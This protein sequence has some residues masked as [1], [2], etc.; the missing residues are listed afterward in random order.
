[1]HVLFSKIVKHKQWLVNT[2]SEKNICK[3]TCLKETACWSNIKI[4]AHACLLDLFSFKLYIYT[5]KQPSEF[6]RVIAI[7]SNTIRVI[8]R[9]IFLEKNTFFIFK[10]WHNSLKWHKWGKNQTKRNYYILLLATFYIDC[11]F[12]FIVA[13]LR[14]YMFFNNHSVCY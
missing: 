14:F 5:F 11:I 9:V 13:L 7:V 4:R 1:M 10:N 2:L 3:K 12:S 6:T 8:R